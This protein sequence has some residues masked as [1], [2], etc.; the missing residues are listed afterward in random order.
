MGDLHS[1]QQRASG[2]K[3]GDGQKGAH[4]AVSGV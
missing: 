2:N 3:Q 1:G 4:G